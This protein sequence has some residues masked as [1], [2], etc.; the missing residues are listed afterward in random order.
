M[1]YLTHSNIGGSQSNK[2]ESA[3]FWKSVSGSNTPQL[4]SAAVQSAGLD[5]NQPQTKE[6]SSSFHRG[7]ETSAADTHRCT[8]RTETS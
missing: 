4:E 8:R 2:K 6:E 1:Q 7:A 3:A 5:L